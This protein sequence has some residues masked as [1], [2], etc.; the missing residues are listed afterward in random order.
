MQS[1]G[2]NR[3]ALKLSAKQEKNQRE[4]MKL[5]Q[6]PLAGSRAGCWSFGVME[7]AKQIKKTTHNPRMSAGC[8]CLGGTAIKFAR[9]KRACRS[10]GGLARKK[11]TRRVTAEA[12]RREAVSARRW[13]RASCST[14]PASSEP[15]RSVQVGGQRLHADSKACDAAFL[16]AQSAGGL[17]QTGAGCITLPSARQTALAGWRVRAGA[18]MLW[19]SFPSLPTEMKAR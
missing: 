13:Q 5:S 17:A 12:P 11:T 18:Q 10:A 15:R 6:Q 9:S 14:S 2:T 4:A 8:Q 3:A 19:R 1:L 7:A 16:Q